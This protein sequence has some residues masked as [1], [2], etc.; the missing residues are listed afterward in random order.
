MKKMLIDM[1]TYRRRA[2]FDYFRTMAYPYVGVTAS[3]G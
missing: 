2:H 1:N 3:G